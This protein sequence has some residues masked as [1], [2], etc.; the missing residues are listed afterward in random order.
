MPYGMLAL[1]MYY[2]EGAGN[3]PKV[4]LIK[5]SFQGGALASGLQI[6]TVGLKDNVKS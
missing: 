5:E 1:A 4:E 2:K 3:D 6:K